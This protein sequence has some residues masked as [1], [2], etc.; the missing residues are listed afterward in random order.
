MRAKRSPSQILFGLLPEQTVDI[1]GG[2]WKVAE[3]RSP[4]VQE[5][6]DANLREE[7]IRQATIWEAEQKDAGFA[8][9]LR[10]NAKIELVRV[11]TSGVRVERFPR[12]LICRNCNRLTWSPNTECCNRRRWGQLH[13]VAYHDCGRVQEPT[14]PLCSD[15]RAARL[16]NPGTGSARELR[17]ECPICNRTLQKGLSV[18]QCACGK[19]AMRVT[20]H[21]ASSVYTPRTAVVVNAA[22]R[23]VMDAIETAG[24]SARAL[25]WI[26]GGMT[27]RNVTETTPT[28][29][30]FVEDLVSK[31]LSRELASEMAD[32]AVAKGELRPDPE[33]DAV[34]PADPKS[35]EREAITIASALHGCRTRVTDLDS[36]TAE[37]IARQLRYTGSIRAAGLESVDLSDR[38]P[39]LTAV[40][41]YTRGELNAGKS[42]LNSFRLPNSNAYAAHIE[43]TETEALFVRLD[44]LRVHRWLASRG[45]HLESADDAE[46]ARRAIL[47]D[48][49]WPM[50]GNDVGNPPSM[51]ETVLMLVHSF[52]HRMLRKLPVLAGIDRDSLSELLVPSHLGFFV[53]A[54]QRGFVLGG[55][56]A[57]FENDLDNLLDSI[58]RAERRCAMDPGCS[59]T[60]SACACCLHVGEPSCRWF[61][62]YLDRLL[63][64]SYLDSVRAGT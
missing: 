59:N 3:W 21:R 31:G 37:G 60:G 48:A 2:I 18:R 10:S 54:A 23:K 16:V 44:P 22:N 24:G 46:Q 41:G 43:R 33:T 12:L 52:A 53:Y 55:L 39:V 28:R 61:N 35:A 13:F 19:G 11:S 27:S 17:F 34:E 45:F 32:R 6:D 29:T 63:L 1:E 38:F 64:H 9:A 47:A 15:H 42:I 51:G 40:Y 4:G 5:C 25:E 57:L 62:R 30:S 36:T 58:T 49:R 56:Q 8:S 7:L 20:V 50:P 14:V 26:L